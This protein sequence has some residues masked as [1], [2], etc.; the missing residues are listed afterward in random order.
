MRARKYGRHDSEDDAT[1]VG[2]EAVEKTAEG[3]GKHTLARCMEKEGRD[4]QKG[5]MEGTSREH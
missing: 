3:D 4:G 5:K 2:T 1:G